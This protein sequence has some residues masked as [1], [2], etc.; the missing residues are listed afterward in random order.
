METGDSKSGE[1]IRKEPGLDKP[2]RAGANPRA[3]HCGAGSPCRSGSK[4]APGSKT[5]CNCNDA[6]AVCSFSGRK[7]ACAS[8]VSSL[9]LRRQQY[10]RRN[11]RRIRTRAARLR[12]IAAESRP[13]ENRVVCRRRH[14][15][16]RAHCVGRGLI[17][18][19]R[20]RRRALGAPCRSTVIPRPRQF[21]YIADGACVLSLLLYA[22]NRFFFKP[23]HVG[24]WFT[25]GY[26]N[27]ILCLPLFVPII[28]Y[29]QHLIGLR[30]H[31]G[32]PRMG[33][34]PKP[35]GLYARLP[36]RGSPLPERLHRCGRPVGHRRIRDR[37][38]PRRVL[39]VVLRSDSQCT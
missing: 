23:H 26:L 6:S 28:L 18:D 35:G 8:I 30:K 39:L 24:G 17:S 32:F 9:P 5:A 10:D 1:E 16:Q 31:R 25:H 2:P 11:E 27:D 34:I 12:H 3:L 21:R 36:N 15:R 33:D 37:R 7:L 20:R 22:V 29:V 13:V 19:A 4:S 14:D 38:G